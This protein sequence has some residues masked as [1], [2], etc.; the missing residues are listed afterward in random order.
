MKKTVIIEHDRVTGK[1]V[2][3]VMLYQ[4]HLTHA[5]LVFFMHGYTGSKMGDIAYGVRLAEE[6]FFTVL[7]DARLH[8]ERK[9]A[10]FETVFGG[11]DA[12]KKTCLDMVC[13]N[14]EDIR[15]IMDEL[16]DDPRVDTERTGITGVSMG[17]FTSFMLSLQEPRVKVLAPMIASPT[18][19]VLSS[20][21]ELEGDAGFNARLREADA[22][23]HIERLLPKSL[24]VQNGVQDEVIPIRG[25]REL[26]EKIRSIAPDKEDYQFIEYE[27]IG[28]TVP[29]EMF[30]AVV[31]WLQKYL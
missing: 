6:G 18:W 23:L 17:G 15:A 9:P 2:P 29:E 5:P 12:F 7:I 26:D 10:D 11:Q 4:P 20:S 28:H 21:E 14:V 24:L 31:A 13:G 22:L 25:A 27:G 16:Q 3:A 8:G 30:E 1:D 19:D